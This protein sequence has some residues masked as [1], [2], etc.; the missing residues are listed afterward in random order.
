M[1]GGADSERGKNAEMCRAV[2]VYTCVRVCLVDGEIID[3]VLYWAR[4]Q[5]KVLYDGY[6]NKNKSHVSTRT[7]L[8][9]NVVEAG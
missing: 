7:W 2:C 6:C 8:A 3:T 5:I 1:Q 4:G 9:S